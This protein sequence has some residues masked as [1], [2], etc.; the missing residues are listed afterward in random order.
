M[1]LRDLGMTWPPLLLLERQIP[2]FGRRANCHNIKG[3]NVVPKY[4]VI[5]IGAS[6]M[7][8]GHEVNCERST[9]LDCFEWL[10]GRRSSF[11]ACPPP[12][13]LPSERRCAKRR[14]SEHR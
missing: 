10:T 4:N 8:S 2:F 13:R 7:G 1:S 12:Q 9:L 5:F 11:L 14:M 6:S 3:I